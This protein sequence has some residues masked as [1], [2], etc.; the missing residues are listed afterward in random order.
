MA[1]TALSRRSS[2]TR[3]CRSTPLFRPP[4]MSTT[5]SKPATAA[6][7]AWGVVAFESSYQRTPSRSATSSTRWGRPLN[8]RSP[9]ATASGSTP[10]ETAM[11]DAA[12]ALRRSWGN[13]L[14]NSSTPSSGIPGHDQPVAVDAVVPPADRHR[15][16][17]RMTGDDGIVEI[18]DR[19]R[20]GCPVPPD[21]GL[22]RLVGRQVGVDV[23][24]IGGEVQPGRH[25]WAPPGGVPEP[26]RGRLHDEARRVRIV[27]GA[28][29]AGRRCCRRPPPADRPASGPVR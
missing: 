27:D 4:A 11:A 24:V 16:G 5:D 7:V 21:A 9:T 25:L 14:H 29:P 19:H 10:S 20:S 17:R 3:S 22:G 26:E 6:L 23:E 28:R 2:A 18:G 1:T 13:G 8:P 15:V 12:R